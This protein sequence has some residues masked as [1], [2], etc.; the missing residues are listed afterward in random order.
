TFITGDAGFVNEYFNESRDGFLF[1]E[2]KTL[3][4]AGAFDEGGNFIQVAFGALSLVEL[5][6]VIG[7]A[8]GP[9]YDYHL[10][11]A[12]AA[13]NNAANVGAASRLGVDI[14]N[15]ARPNGGLNDIGADEAM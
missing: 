6:G 11:A 2:F 8:E 13:I 1:P 14:D 7:N 10:T 3:A 5:D 12:S 15:E 4:T 9:L